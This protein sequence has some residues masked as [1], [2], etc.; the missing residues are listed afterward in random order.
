MQTYTFKE[1]GCLELQ[2]DVYLPDH[3]DGPLATVVSLHGG[4]LIMGSRRDFDGRLVD[5]LM[6]AGIA[7]VSPDYRLAPETKLPEIWMDV[8]ASFRW[9]REE[10][11][12]LWGADPDR[13]GVHGVS[14]GGYLALLAGC[15][16]E[17][18]L[19]VVGSYAG[20]GDIT[21]A[22]YAEPSEWYCSRDPIPEATARAAVGQGVPVDGQCARASYYCYLRQ[23]GLWPEQVGGSADLEG[24]CPLR[25]A[26]SSFP[27]AVLFHGAV[28]HDVP[29]EQSAAFVTLLEERGVE[30]RF[31]PLEGVDHV[32]SGASDVDAERVREETAAFMI[33]RLGSTSAA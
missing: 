28:D 27:P 32:F 11:P 33:E 16:I 13:I 8:A 23:N 15:R 30:H 9:V 17:P 10:G 3:V 21:A 5:K 18:A 20:Y 31:L 6:E 1:V 4:A 7:V 19:R 25:I 2:A 26:T 12:A 22:W 24:Y 29:Y 14:A